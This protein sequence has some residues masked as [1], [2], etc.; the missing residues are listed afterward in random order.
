MEDVDADPLA[1][2]NA[3]I[4]SDE[5]TCRGYMLERRKGL[6]VS[7]VGS[8]YDVLPAKA[9]LKVRPMLLEMHQIGVAHGDLCF[10]NI[11]Y[12]LASDTVALF[13]FSESCIRS[14]T[15]GH[16]NFEVACEE[17]L[18]ALDD[19]LEYVTENQKSCR[20]MLP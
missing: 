20:Y 16:Q 7:W 17:D 10:R 18:Q 11:G 1:Q 15:Q 2:E 5:K 14:A 4:D 3:V 12:D 6:M 9:L 13:N 19:M 8:S